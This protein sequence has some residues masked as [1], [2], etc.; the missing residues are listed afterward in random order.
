MKKC[1][2]CGKDLGY[3]FIKDDKG[4]FYCNEKCKEEYEK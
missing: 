4:N 2:W 3:A 1:Y